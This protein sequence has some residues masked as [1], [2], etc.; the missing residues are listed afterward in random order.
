MSR[1]ACVKDYQVGL[2]PLSLYS[3]KA[4]G[5]CL[6]NEDIPVLREAL[7]TPT[8]VFPGGALP[9]GSCSPTSRSYKKRLRFS[10]ECLRKGIHGSREQSR[11]F[12]PFP[13]SLRETLPGRTTRS[14]GASVCQKRLLP[15]IL[16]PQVHWLYT[17]SPPGIAT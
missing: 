8:Q 6:G 14:L 3:A 1:C 16:Q 15:L 12:P 4:Q 13:F 9:Y 17:S 7:D 5:L 2:F 10:R 11:V